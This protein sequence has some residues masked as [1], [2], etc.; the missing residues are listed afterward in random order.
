MVEQSKMI[1]DGKTVPVARILKNGTNYVK[2]RDVAAALGLEVGFTGNIAVLRSPKKESGSETK[3]AGE[4][5]GA[6]FAWQ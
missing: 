5:S 2:I 6:L 3:R 4:S 1:V